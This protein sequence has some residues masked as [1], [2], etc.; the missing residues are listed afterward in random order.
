MTTRHGMGMPMPDPGDPSRASSRP[1][2]G[3][4][5]AHRFA[6]TVDVGSTLSRWRT[7]LVAGWSTCSSLTR[8]TDAAE[9][10]T[11][12]TESEWLASPDPQW[13]LEVVSD[14]ADDRKLRLFAVACCCRLGAPENKRVGTCLK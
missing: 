13:M 7:D 10:G 5:P 4:F 6:G 3:Q 2:D 9:S 14:K 8:R 1:A 12:M 11:P